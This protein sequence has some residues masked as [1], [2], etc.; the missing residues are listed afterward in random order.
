M[1]ISNNVSMKNYT[2]YKTGGIVK[3]MYFPENE[4]ELIDLLK[5]LKKENIKYFLLA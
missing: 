4:I 5:K 3:S 2:T 1:K